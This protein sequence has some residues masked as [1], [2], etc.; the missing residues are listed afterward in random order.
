LA[1]KKSVELI[2]MHNKTTIKIALIL[3]SK[4]YPNTDIKTLSQ[5]AVAQHCTCTHFSAFSLH[6][7]SVTSKV[8][9]FYYF[10]PYALL[11]NKSTGQAPRDRGLISIPE[12]T[13]LSDYHVS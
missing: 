9:V 13:V 8:S 6:A 1:K 2:K 11:L 5:S 4:D 12:N 10:R 3:V 7:N